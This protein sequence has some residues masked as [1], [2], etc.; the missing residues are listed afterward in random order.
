MLHGAFVRSPHAHARILGIDA[1]EALAMPGVKAVVTGADFP[2]V[3]G[4]DIEGGEG[5][6]DYADL[7]C[8][9]MARDKVLYHGHAVAA[10]AAT[11]LA[12]ARE[13]ARRVKVEYEP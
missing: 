11:S 10:I 2:P 9:V 12:V 6:G 4:G 1:D 3:A 8:N 7:A 5:G 13:A